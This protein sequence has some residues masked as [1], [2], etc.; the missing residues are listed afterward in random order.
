[1]R[2]AALAPRANCPSGVPGAALDR[3]KST[4]TTGGLSR[5]R[6]RS[7]PHSSSSP[8]GRR[9]GRAP[10]RRVTTSTTNG[11]L[12][13][14]RTSL[15]C[16]APA[17]SAAPRLAA[18]P[19]RRR[20]PAPPAGRPRRGL[21]GT[22]QRL[23]RPRPPSALTQA[24]EPATQPIRTPPRG[25]ARAPPRR[26]PRATGRHHGHRPRG[27]RASPAGGGG[28]ASLVPP[29]LGRG[30]GGGQRQPQGDQRLA[31]ARHVAQGDGT[32]TGV[33]LAAPAPPLAR[34][35]HRRG[36]SLGNARGI[37]HQPPRGMSPGLGD[38]SRP[39]L[40]SGP[41][42]PRSP[43]HAALQGQAVLAKAI[44]DRGDICACHSREQTTEKGM[45]M[46]LAFWAA[47]GRHKGRQKG[48]QPRQPLVEE[49]GGNLTC[50]QPWWLASGVSRFP[51][52]APSVNR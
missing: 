20:V 47:E 49:R 23:A 32:W 4:C 52:H 7:M 18:V 28:P 17:A 13:P 34:H 45:G 39:L 43:A 15:R 24:M 42:L 19:G 51:R 1:M 21:Q 25:S 33:D 22:S 38:V 16:Q 8:W 41:L 2:C 5:S 27:P 46:L 3:E 10:T 36:P 31:R 26:A 35:A 29:G 48:W 40:T 11:P 14:A 50:R 44:R 37:A 6:S 9:G 12:E 30:P